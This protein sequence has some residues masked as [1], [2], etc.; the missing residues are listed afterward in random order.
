MKHFD[1]EAAIQNILEA[2]DIQR[3]RR[4]RLSENI[5][6]IIEVIECEEWDSGNVTSVILYR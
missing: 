6:V 4:T 1:G 2:S 3:E 5:E